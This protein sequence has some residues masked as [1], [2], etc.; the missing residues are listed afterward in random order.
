MRPTVPQAYVDQLLFSL[1][2]YTLQK[3][4]L[5]AGLCFAGVIVPCRSTVWRVLKKPHSAV[6]QLDIGPSATL[7]KSNITGITDLQHILT[8]ADIARLGAGKG[9]GSLDGVLEGVRKGKFEIA[10]GNMCAHLPPTTY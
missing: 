6:S 1:V 10:G 9:T 5:R 3:V 2:C 4:A 7:L 8:H